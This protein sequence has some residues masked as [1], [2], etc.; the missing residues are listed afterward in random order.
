LSTN[1]PV[2]LAVVVAGA[3]VAAGIENV[4]RG[5]RN[6]DRPHVNY[7]TLNN[8]GTTDLNYAASADA[9]ARRQSNAAALAH[10]RPNKTA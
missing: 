10:A 9:T 5:R 6:A 1:A 8:T 2:V 7:D 3:V 4:R